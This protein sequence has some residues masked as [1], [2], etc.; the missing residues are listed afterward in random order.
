M[1]ELAANVVSRRKGY[2]HNKKGCCTFRAT[3]F[4]LFSV[5]LCALFAKGDVN[6]LHLTAACDGDL[7]GVTG[8]VVP[9]EEA[10]LHE[11][12]DRLAADPAFAARLSAN[13]EQAFRTR[14]TYYHAGKE[15]GAQV[16]ESEVV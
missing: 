16:S 2:F 1:G 7:D 5:I 11:A 14:F 6:G 4:L 12:M 9:K 15:V 10:A 3:A 13:A 8:L